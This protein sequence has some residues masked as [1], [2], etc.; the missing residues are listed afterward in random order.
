M[1]EPPG[2]GRR[3]ALVTAAAGGLLAG[4][5][6]CG[7]LAGGP[8]PPAAAT[9]RERRVPDSSGRP[10]DDPLVFSPREERTL[11]RPHWIRQMRQASVLLLGEVHDNPRH[12]RIRAELLRLWARADEGRR[13]AIVFE[14]FDRE[15]GDYLREATD[16]APAE[17]PPL[18]RL[19]K[20]AAF[21][22]RGW[23]WPVHRPLFEA[24]RD[25]DAVWIAAGLPRQRR[26]R[27]SAGEATDPL[28]RIVSAS[29][30]PATAQRTLEQS[31]VDGHCGQLPA[32][33]VPTMVGI[34][35]RRDASLAETALTA[36]ERRVLVLAGNGHVGRVHGVPRYL[37][38]VSGEVLAVGFLEQKA[39]VPLEAATVADD[40]DWVVATE[41]APREDPCLAFSRSAP[42]RT[43]AR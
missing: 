40:Y 3:R 32:S 9:P 35:R 33:V 1:A 20:G 37:G 8:V 15:Q 41:A 38:A 42:T 17:R 4:L 27:P 21:D 39:G 29:D 7:G 34:Q 12:H 11:A 26:S 14:H 16:R 22:E 2:G 28:D 24:A 25:A 23:G 5:A 36:P 10:D 6:G 19:L 31:L 30:W 43:P 13:P 18:E